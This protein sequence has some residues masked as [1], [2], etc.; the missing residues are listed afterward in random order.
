MSLPIT[1]SELQK[2]NWRWEEV[3]EKTSQDCCSHSKCLY[4]LYSGPVL[5]PNIEVTSATSFPKEGVS[6]SFSQPCVV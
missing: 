6:I 4:A 1:K 5:G 3:A 2:D